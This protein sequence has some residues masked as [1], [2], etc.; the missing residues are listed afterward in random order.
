MKEWIKSGMLVGGKQVQEGWLFPKNITFTKDVPE[1]T[2]DKQDAVPFLQVKERVK[3]PQGPRWTRAAMYEYLLAQYGARCQGC[4][5][6]FDDQR[7]LQLDHNTPRADG[8]ITHNSNR[9]L[10]CGPCNQLKSNIYTLSGLRRE[11]HK[12][13]YMAKTG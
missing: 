4:D 8:G 13:G 5:R 2:D 6:I 12:R 10:L 7:Y 3:E 9:I 11:N 1:C